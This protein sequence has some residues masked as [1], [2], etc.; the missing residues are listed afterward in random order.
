MFNRYLKGF[1]GEKTKNKIKNN[2]KNPGFFMLVFF[3]G[4]CFFWVGFL[5]PTLALGIPPDC[6]CF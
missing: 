5:L 6:C 1:Y 4:G 2:P 3:F